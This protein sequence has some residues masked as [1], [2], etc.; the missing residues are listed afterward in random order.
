MKN[1]EKIKEYH[2]NHPER[3]KEDPVRNRG[4]IP[5]TA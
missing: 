5:E 3:R 2:C 4:I 1:L